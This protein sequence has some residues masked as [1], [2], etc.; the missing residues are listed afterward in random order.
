MTLGSEIL[1]S[2]EAGSEPLSTLMWRA[3][4]TAAGKMPPAQGACYPTDI[5]AGR[6]PGERTRAGAH[7]AHQHM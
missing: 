4:S 1:S 6:A 5:T 2:T 3:S 7:A